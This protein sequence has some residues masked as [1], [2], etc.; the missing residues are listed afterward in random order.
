[1]RHRAR[2]RH[3]FAHRLPADMVVTN[4]E[5]RKHAEEIWKLPDGLMPDKVGYHI[6]EQDR[7]LKDGKLNFYWVQAN[8][9]VQAARILANE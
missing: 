6:V 3:L 8:N 4:P 1:V 7:M 2:G 5:H 9:N